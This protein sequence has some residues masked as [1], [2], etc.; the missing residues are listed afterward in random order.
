MTRIKTDTDLTEPGI[1]IMDFLTQLA[2]SFLL[3][4]I[5]LIVWGFRSDK[6][7]SD[8]KYENT[9]NPQ[10]YRIHIEGLYNHLRIRL[11]GRFARS[12]YEIVR[13]SDLRE[14]IIQHLVT[15]YTYKE[16]KIPEV[17]ERFLRASSA[18]KHNL[19]P[20]LSDYIVEEFHKSFYHIYQIMKAL[21]PVGICDICKNNY[22][23]TDKKKLLQILENYH[24]HRDEFKNLFESN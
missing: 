4:I 13:D 6:K 22:V 14:Q 10:E 20:P 16:E 24:K 11:E 5:P 2:I 7:E 15:Y 19:H 23:E 18:K 3:L 12:F 17:F 8:T 21:Q 1:N 9:P